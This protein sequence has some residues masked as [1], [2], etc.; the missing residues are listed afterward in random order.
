MTTV[1]MNISMP[2]TLRDHVEAQVKARGYTSASEYVRELVRRDDER[3][4]E[5]RLRA[6]I[7]DG[8]DS[9]PGRDWNEIRADFLTRSRRAAKTPV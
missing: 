1:T 4:A 6:K 7:Q 9:G 2:E 8:I 5:D 3:R